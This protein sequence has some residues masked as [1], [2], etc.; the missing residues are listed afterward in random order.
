MLLS[1]HDAYDVAQ[2]YIGCH[3]RCRLS[4]VTMVQ[5]NDSTANRHRLALVLRQLKQTL[6]LDNHI[7]KGT[8][9]KTIISLSMPIAHC[10]SSL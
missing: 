3:F 2:S 1:T 4:H 6:Y 8:H 5:N 10:L 9:P 7:P